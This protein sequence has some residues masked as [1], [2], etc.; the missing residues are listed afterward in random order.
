M[1]RLDRRDHIDAQLLTKSRH[2]PS[3]VAKG[4]GVDNVDGTLLTH[5]LLFGD[6]AE[7]HVVT[8]RW[9]LAALDDESLRLSGSE[10]LSGTLPQK[11]SVRQL[12]IN[13]G[14]DELPTATCREHVVNEPSAGVGRRAPGRTRNAVRSVV[15][16]T[17]VIQVDEGLGI[18]TP[19]CRGSRSASRP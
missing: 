4:R 1:P 18:A 15:A 6:V 12:R 16:V 10:Y 14:D 19:T 2:W 8:D 17:G 13:V 11:K 3:D 5:L 7:H 9:C